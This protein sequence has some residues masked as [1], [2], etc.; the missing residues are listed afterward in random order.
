MGV[1][2]DKDLLAVEQNNYS[3]KNVY[4]YSVYELRTWLRVPLDNLKLQNCLSDAT[5]MIKK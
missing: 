5:K 3:T 2:S 1:K 4:A